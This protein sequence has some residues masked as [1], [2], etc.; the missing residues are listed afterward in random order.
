MKAGTTNTL[1]QQVQRKKDW[2]MH[3]EWKGTKILVYTNDYIYNIAVI[4]IIN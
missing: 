2:F 4:K 1:P 3:Y